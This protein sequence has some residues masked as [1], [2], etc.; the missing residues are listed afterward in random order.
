MKNLNEKRAEKMQDN[1]LWTPLDCLK[2]LVRDIEIG[3][4]NPCALHV[5]YWE[6]NDG[7]ENKESSKSYKYASSNLTRP[8]EIALLNVALKYALEDWIE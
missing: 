7:S 2:A 5:S 3:D 1:R 4:I 8:E 6:T